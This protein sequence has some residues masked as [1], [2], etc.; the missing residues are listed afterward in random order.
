MTDYYSRFKLNRKTK[1]GIVLITLFTLVFIS[2]IY[3]PKFKKKFFKSENTNISN[4]N[5]LFGIDISHHN[6]T[7]NWDE[8]KKSKHPISYVFIKATEGQK[9]VDK[10]F[11]YNWEKA[12]ENGYIKG[13]YHFYRP[14]INSATQFHHFSS[15]V[16]LE[17]GD[18]LPVLDIERESSL[19][20]D[21]LV[22]G[23]RNWVNLCEKSY[24]VKPIIYTGRKFYTKFLKD[25]FSDCPLWIA[26]YSNE[27]SI[28]ELKWDLHQF[29]EKVI[30]KGVPENVDGNNFKGDLF[31][32]KEN[33]CIK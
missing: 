33:Y 19:G 6:G 25:E 28:S 22:E 20:K 17:K 7:I 14:G 29:T 32:L 16:K 26:S 13:A 9:L 15:T 23:V 27:N 5:Y 2:F 1:Y 10:R 18:L 21:N 30:V 24:G 3:S 31:K 4:T 12:K 11:H 8:V